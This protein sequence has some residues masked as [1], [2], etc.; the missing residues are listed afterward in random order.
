MTSSDRSASHTAIGVAAMRAVHQLYDGE[1]R[2][3]DDP[4]ILKLLA[5]EVLDRTRAELDRLQTRGMR[6]LRS[7]VVLRSRYAEDCLAE[8]SSRG[9]RQYVLLG[10]GFDTFAYRQPSWAG[11]L[12]IFEVD[13]AASQEAKRAR[14]DSAGIALPTNLEFVVADF[15]K[16]SLREILE[17]S[18]FDFSQPAFLSCLGVL[19]YLDEQSIDALFK[20]VGSLAKSTEF[21]FTF[22]PTS[23]EDTD[24]WNRLAQAVAAVGEPLR[25]QHDPERL[26]EQLLASGFTQVHFLSPEESRLRYYQYRSDDLPP[27]RHSSIG[28]AVV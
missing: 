18:S 20:L 7:H 24:G 9:V 25:T 14:L 13:H 17:R 27:P 21:V 22:S 15:E 1:P 23:R 11:S 10:A 6:A 2:I 16:H 28:R 19:V 12:K 5:P 3:F 8:A 26:R 4:V